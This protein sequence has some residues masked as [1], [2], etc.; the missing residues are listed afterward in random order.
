MYKNYILNFAV[1]YIDYY[2]K[3]TVNYFREGK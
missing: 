2:L 1:K 3:K